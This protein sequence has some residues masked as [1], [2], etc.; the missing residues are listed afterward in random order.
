M[1]QDI[2]MW[3]MIAAT[4]VLVFLLVLRFRW[5]DIRLQRAEIRTEFIE[6][7]YRKNLLEQ[8]IRERPYLV[9]E[10]KQWKETP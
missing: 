1:K 5:L 7:H 6:Q 10:Y 3:L 9:R 2:F 8:H 4:L